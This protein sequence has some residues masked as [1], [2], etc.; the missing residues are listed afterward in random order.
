[1][2]IT[3]DGTA[4]ITTPAILNSNSNGVGNIGTATTTW[5][6]VFAK[7]TS[8]Q[9]ADLSENY[10]A[11]MPYPPGTLVE[12]GGEA[13]VTITTISSSTKIAGIVST[14]P[15]YLMNSGEDDPNAVP[16]A[17]VG[18]VPCRVIG[19]I[20][21]GDRLVSSEI[22]GVAKK[23]SDSEYQPG[24]IVGKALDSYSG[25]EPGIIEVVV[26]RL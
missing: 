24:C 15:A 20:E 18:R 17:L 22:P 6:V 9:Y 7:A 11:D 13:E 4:G 8:A 5:N 12:F 16:V 25:T 3:L 1:M 26:G 19:T 23:L 21:K 14:E 2:A 10:V